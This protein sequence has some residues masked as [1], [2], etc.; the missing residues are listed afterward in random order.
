MFSRC[1]DDNIIFFYSYIYHAGYKELLFFF[2]LWNKIFTWYQNTKNSK[3]ILIKK[4]AEII[5]FSIGIYFQVIL[6]GSEET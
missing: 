4:V 6:L 2:N 5:I 1:P 3:I